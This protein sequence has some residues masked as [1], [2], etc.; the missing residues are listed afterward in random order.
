MVRL[1]FRCTY[2]KIAKRITEN[3]AFIAVG[4][5]TADLGLSVTFTGFVQGIYYR[6]E[7]SYP[8]SERPGAVKGGLTRDHI[9]A[10]HE[11]PIAKKLAVF[12]QKS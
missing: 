2:A 4:I 9:N 5:C 1:L 11:S 12:Q 3:P 10:I 7:W 8:T 6:I